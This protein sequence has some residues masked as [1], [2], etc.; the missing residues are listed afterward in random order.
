MAATLTPMKYP[1]FTPHT[2]MIYI[3]AVLTHLV[4][5]ALADPR[6]GVTDRD[7]GVGDVTEPRTLPNTLIS[8]DIAT[9]Q[10]TPN[11]T[12]PLFRPHTVLSA[13]KFFPV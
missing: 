9:A 10:Y 12:P 5:G 2:V 4:L 6:S 7:S 1:C 8:T 13:H 3:I 11:I